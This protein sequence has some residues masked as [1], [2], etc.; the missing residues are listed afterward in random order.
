M[1][2]TIKLII[3]LTQRN[4]RNILYFIRINVEICPLELIV[5]T[6]LQ[7]PVTMCKT[8]VQNHGEAS[9]RHRDAQRS[10]TAEWNQGWN[11]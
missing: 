7:V 5:S 6:L 10:R 3:G 9:E 1:H 2:F 4:I 8:D 11:V